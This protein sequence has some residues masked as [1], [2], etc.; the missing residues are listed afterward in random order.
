MKISL[1]FATLVM[2]F[3]LIAGGCAE[4]GS[5]GKS[6]KKNDNKCK[7]GETYSDYY[8]ECL[9]DSSCPSGEAIIPGTNQCGPVNPGEDFDPNSGQLKWITGNLNVTNS[10]KFA[11]FVESWGYTAYGRAFCV[12]NNDDINF[13]A[14]WGWLG[15][16]W[17]VGLAGG[18]NCNTY[19]G[20]ELWIGLNKQKVELDESTVAQVFLRVR[21]SWG[22]QV[23]IKLP[24]DAQFSVVR[25]ANQ[26]QNFII[27]GYLYKL[28]HP[29]DWAYWYVEG[30]LTSNQE[31]TGGTISVKW[32]G[33]VMA[34]SNTNL[35]Q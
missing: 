33:P 1:F 12:D 6:P 5:K 35:F 22:Q 25:R 29:Q 23:D 8:E 9:E 34:T 30:P 13:Y 3:G 16:N 18:Q 2:A 11:A 32:D 21:S 26:D 10:G 24:H 7:S 17:N 28:T 14:G 15:S 31:I 20:V 4:S 19:D 27:Q